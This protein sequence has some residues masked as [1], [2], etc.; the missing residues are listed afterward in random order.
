MNKTAI[1]IALIA[2]VLAAAWLYLW[3]NKDR[4]QYVPAQGVKY[5]PPAVFDRNTGKVE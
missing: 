5:A 3:Y 4:Y 1:V 2:A